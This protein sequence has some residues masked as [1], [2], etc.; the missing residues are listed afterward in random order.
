MRLRPVDEHFVAGAGT[1]VGRQPPAP[2]SPRLWSV[3]HCDLG[4]DADWGVDG[5]PAVD[6]LYATN[7]HLWCGVGEQWYDIFGP[8]G[9]VLALRPTA[10]V[11]PALHVQSRQPILVQPGHAQRHMQG[12][13]RGSG[14]QTV[15]VNV[16][17]VP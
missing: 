10:P 4:A 3:T 12:L 8:L 6:A 15:S 2:R 7:G 17:T 11:S 13:D 9:P 16:L 14:E 1:A 5:H